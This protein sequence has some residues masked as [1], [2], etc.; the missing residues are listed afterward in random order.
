MNGLPNFA[1]SFNLRLY[2]LVF[3]ATCFTGIYLGAKAGAYTRSL[4]SST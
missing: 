1:F 3:T 2:T 4:L